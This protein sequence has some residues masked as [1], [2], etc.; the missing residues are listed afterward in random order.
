[1]KRK[2]YTFSIDAYTDFTCVGI[3]MAQSENILIE[4]S[5][6]DKEVETIKSHVKKSTFDSDSGLM[7]I[8]ESDTPELYDRIDKAAK[9]AILERMSQKDAEVMAIYRDEE[10][11]D[12]EL[13]LQE[14]DV[15]DV[16]YICH[17]PNF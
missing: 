10:P 7:P 8:L 9:K 6:S 3:P 17:I 14:E 12:D 11:D 2:N 1:M 16:P 13:F 4:V 5:L 15:C